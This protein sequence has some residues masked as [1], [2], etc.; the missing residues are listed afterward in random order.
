MARARDVV[1]DRGIGIIP[2]R[3]SG[4]CMDVR[5]GGSP[6]SLGEVE[7]AVRADVDEPPAGDRTPAGRRRAVAGEP[8]QAAGVMERAGR[9]KPLHPS[10]RRRPAEF[11]GARVRSVAVS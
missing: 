5:D 4:G 1:S 11:A 7:H 10:R 2:G 9:P 6:V 3:A 8:L